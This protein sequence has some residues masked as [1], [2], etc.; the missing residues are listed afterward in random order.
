MGLESV[1][2]RPAYPTRWSHR[3]WKG[4]NTS[5][6]LS[7]MITRLRYP[8]SAAQH[9][10]PTAKRRRSIVGEE[11]LICSRQMIERLAR[12]Y[13]LPWTDCIN[14]QYMIWTYYYSKPYHCDSKRQHHSICPASNA[15]QSYLLRRVYAWI[16]FAR[17]EEWLSY[18]SSFAHRVRL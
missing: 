2:L 12:V 16:E 14:G 17:H 8:R 7:S 13:G 9:A 11:A 5:F 10:I 3:L 1:D 18:K 6:P 15:T 4:N